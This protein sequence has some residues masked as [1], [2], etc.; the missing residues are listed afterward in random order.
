[1]VK[2]CADFCYLAIQ[3]SIIIIIII[4]S[5]LILTVED[6]AGEIDDGGQADVIILD[7]LKASNKV[8]HKHLLLKLD[9]YGIRGKTKRLIE[10][11]LSNSTQQTVVKGKDC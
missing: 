9:F 6:L 10:D 11:F 4:E 8:P 3:I 7:S 1:M 5:H 2:R